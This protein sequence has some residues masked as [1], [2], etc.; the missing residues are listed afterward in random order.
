VTVNPVIVLLAG[1]RQAVGMSQQQV[2]EAM[3]TRQSAVSEL[4]S[5]GSPNPCWS[6]LTRYAVAVGVRLE[7]RITVPIAADGTTPA[8]AGEPEAQSNQDLGGSGE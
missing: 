1:V 8:L 7:V 2:A 5:G 3:G 6:T 4:E